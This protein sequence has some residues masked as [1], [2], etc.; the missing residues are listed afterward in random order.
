MEATNKEAS[1]QLDTVKT[2]SNRSSPQKSESSEN[3]DNLTISLKEGGDGSTQE[4]NEND[5]EEDLELL[6]YQR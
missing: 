3:Y 1:L 6:E 2:L 5:L 4:G